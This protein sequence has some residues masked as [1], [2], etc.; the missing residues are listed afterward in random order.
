[1][2]RR[3]FLKKSALTLAGGITL[4]NLPMFGAIDETIEPLKNPEKAG[5]NTNKKIGVAIMGLGTFATITIGPEIASSEHVWLAG[6]ITG[7]P[8]G[9]GKDWAKQYGF[10]EKNIYSYDQI[11]Q[12][13]NNPDIDFIHVVTPTGLHAKYTIA[14]AKTGKHILC[15]KPMA[16][17]STQCKSM[18]N[19]CKKAGVI[20][21]VNYRLHW[22]PHH[23]KMMELIN[24]KTY[25]ELRSIDAEFSW[26]RND[27]KKLWLLDKKM[28]GGGSF[29]D[30]GIYSIQAGCYL[31]DSQPIC[32]TAI[33]TTTRDVYPKGIEETMTAIFEFPHGV[34]LSARS[35]YAYG[36]NVFTAACTDGTII[37][38]SKSPFGQS[39]RG[40][41]S[42]KSLK[43]PDDKA[44][45][46]V[47]TLQVAV[48]YD[49]FAEAMMTKTPFKASG[50]M[51]LRDIQITEAV[52][53]SV[54]SG[55]TE[56]IEYL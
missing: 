17:S 28:A 34:V 20:L 25:G 30:T 13:K 3:S 24:N 35:S 40:K 29:F 36:Y 44:F 9:K 22:E 15:E 19:A 16:I 27:A 10:P 12:I 2:E 4:L 5:G 6:V 46:A 8:E 56:K 39:L 7:D 55:K 23:Q 43:L 49:A 51:G 42:I 37:C 18:I 14:A 21:G 45:K 38:E 54:A 32:V 50:E 11:D 47:D 48:L 1:M 41:P 26:K 52:Y 31:T 53:K 33:P